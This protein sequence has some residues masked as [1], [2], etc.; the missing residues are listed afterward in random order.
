MGA[1]LPII[2]GWGVVRVFRSFG[3]GV[4]RQASSHIILTKP[5]EIV[6]LSVPNHKEVAKGTLRSLIR[7]A[8]LTVEEFVDAS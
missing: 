6:T 7:A 8:R 5:G 4:A 2:S 3:W 1:K